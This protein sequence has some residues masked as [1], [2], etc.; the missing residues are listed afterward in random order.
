MNTKIEINPRLSED[1]AL[2]RQPRFVRPNE[3]L[4]IWWMGD[5]KITFQATCQ[6]TDGAY[7]FWIDEPPAQIGPPKHVHSREEE[8]FFVIEG[9]VEF[10]AGNVD[11]VLTNGDFIALPKGI[12]HAW[13]NTSVN[14]AKLITFTA[15]AGNEGFFLTL[16][17]AGVGA[18]GP[19]ATLPLS[20]IN[21][22]TRRFGVTY[23]PFTD[24]PLDASLQ[25]GA[26]RAPAVV[27]AAE[28]DR[29]FACGV[30]Y[31]VKACG[32]V[33]SGAYA[34]IEVIIAPG[35]IM[36]SHHHAAFEEGIYVLEGEVRAIL[37]GETYDAV[38]G[39]FLTIPW[40]LPHEIRNSAD[41]PARLLLLS[42]PG[43]VEDYYRAS[44]RTT[45]DERSPQSVEADVDNMTEV[46]R[47]F[48]VFA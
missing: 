23:V 1:L 24:N 35:G 45:Y 11:A 41:K 27:R 31:V 12:P 21:E 7:S 37:N 20:E 28:G 30:T 5:D 2:I 29:L 13:I 19:R 26:G 14:K 47:R 33:T 16:G 10:K 46:G 3:G 36:P 22:R 9:E 25:I 40:G 8:G 15:P 18:P 39:S 43:G 32:P 4:S 44:C 34:L 42:V 6:S 17:G 38:A 48:G